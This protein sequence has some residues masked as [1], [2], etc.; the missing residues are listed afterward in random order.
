LVDDAAKTYNEMT[1]EDAD[2]LGGQMAGAMSQMQQT[3]ANLPPE[4]RAQVEAMMKARGG[5][6]GA[7]A[8]AKTEYKKTGTDKVGKWTCDKYEGFKA[9]QKTSEV[10]TVDPKAFGLTAADLEITKQLG[11]FFSKMAPQNGDAMFRAGSGDANGFSG[12]PVRIV[13]LAPQQSVTEVT[14]VSRQSFQD[15]IFAV[16]AGYTKQAFGGRGRGRQ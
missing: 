5:G 15:S 13:T 6:P 1:K 3:M 10:C 16:P 11:E 7:G 14:D 4:Q 12:V 8:P 9:G 2:R